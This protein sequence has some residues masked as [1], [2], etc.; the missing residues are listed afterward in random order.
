MKSIDFS[1]FKSKAEPVIERSVSEA[2]PRELNLAKSSS[3]TV[4]PESKSHEASKSLSK[5]ETPKNESASTSTVYKPKDKNINSEMPSTDLL[6]RVLDDGSSSQKSNL[7][8]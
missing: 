6:D 3:T 8:R 4:Q 7:M 1:K 2:K 5:A